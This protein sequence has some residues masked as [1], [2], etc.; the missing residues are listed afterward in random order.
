[1][2]IL[3][4][5]LTIFGLKS[6]QIVEVHE[7]EPLS[8]M[9]RRAASAPV[10][11]DPTN[12]DTQPARVQLR[13]LLQVHGAGKPISLKMR[14]RTVV[15]RG[16]GWDTDV[17]LTPF[18][19]EACGVAR[20]HVAILFSDDTLSVQHLACESSTRLNGVPL[21]PDHLYRLRNGDELELGQLRLTVRTLRVP[22]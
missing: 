14:E 17:D 20:C 13:L 15:G 2:R 21:V 1:M 19:A 12:E 22:L 4:A 5:I 3:N 10:T 18:N 9:F 16:S 7:S 8:T 11:H 6:N